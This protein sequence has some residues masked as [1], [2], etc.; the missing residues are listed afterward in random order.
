MSSLYGPDY[1]I[2]VDGEYTQGFLNEFQPGP[3]VFSYVSGPHYDY[4][5]KSWVLAAYGQKEFSLGASTQLS[6]AARIEYTHYSYDNQI[7][8]GVFGR[9]KR[10]DDRND[11]FLVLTPKLSLIHNFNE[12]WQVY[13]RLARGARAPQTSDL[14]SL[15]INQVVGDIEPETLDSAE[16]GLRFTSERAA[17]ELGGFAMKKDNF[18]FRNTDGYNVANGKTE[19][20]GLELSGNADITHRLSGSF[21]LTLADHS[22]AFSDA[23][24]SASNS[25]TDGDQVDTA[26]SLI[27]NAR[28]DYD[29]TRTLSANF[30]W[31][32]MGEY[33]TDPGN[34]Q[35]YPGHDVFTL[36]GQWDAPDAWTVFARIDNLFDV[37][38]A[39]RADYG[40][41]NERYFPGRARALFVGV[42]KRF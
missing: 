18:F 32:H 20:F 28:V 7:D 41:G 42:E 26:P 2:G 13:G 11:D 8:S 39:D 14:Y 17:F 31:R 40:F 19:H 5:V 25:I 21:N 3:Q 34:T 37:K 30:A 4:Q 27:A 23:V 22:Y 38:Y 16:F 1:I 24:A 6:A 12:N 33:F 9:F 29:L 35:S 36:G 10:I 15:Q